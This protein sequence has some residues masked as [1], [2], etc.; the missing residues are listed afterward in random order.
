MAEPIKIKA[1]KSGVRPD[2]DSEELTA[3]ELAEAENVLRRDGEFRVRPGLDV[4]ASDVNE[5]P[6]KYLQYDHAGSRKVVLGTD[7]G[8]HLLAGSAFVSLTGAALTADDVSHVPV[9]RTF[10]RGTTTFLLGV[11]GKDTMKRWNGT[12]PSY[13]NVS[14]SPPIAGCMMVVFDR[15]VLGNLKSGGTISPVGVDVSAN[16]DFD[17]G[18]GTQLVLLAAETPGPII[19]MEEFGDFNGAIIKSDAIYMLI[20]QG[21]TSPFRKEH[22]KSGISGPASEPLVFRL[23]TG[24]AGWLGNDGLV[25]IFNGANIEP[26]PYHVQ[27]QVISTCAPQHL[28]AGWAAY[29]PERR[30]LWLVYPLLGSTNPNGGCM[31]NM[32]TMAV[33]PMRFPGFALTAGGKVK[34]ETGLT[35]GDMT[36]TIGSLSGT[37]GGLGNSSSIRRMVMGEIGGKSYQDIGVTDEGV[38]IPFHWESGARGELERYTNLGRIRHRFKHTNVTQN[39]SFQLGKRKDFGR[40]TFGT[41]HTI[42]LDAAASAKKVTG[43]RTSAEYFCM[44]YSG[45]ATAE[46]VYDGAAVFGGKGGR[47]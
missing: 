16:K 33:Y 27:K 30:E 18:W 43:H 37:I 32:T 17:T 14:G 10:T 35:I 29:D 2:K 26:L 25:S 40:P 22:I 47:R 36:G 21:G 19:A 46:V 20:A 6:M 8:W 42:N 41:A 45:D 23:K 4:F 11:N 28:N 9:F 39:I 31:V 13:A 15:V 5:R 24:E 44:R 1:P 34:S 38:A 7:R 3:D 12:D